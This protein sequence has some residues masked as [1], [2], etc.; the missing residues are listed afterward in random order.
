MSGRTPTTKEG[1]AGSLAYCL[2]STRR[3]RS[4]FRFAFRLLP[5][6]QRD[7]MHALYAFLRATDDLSDQPGD[8]TAKRTALH[9]WRTR[10]NAALR[11]VHSHRTHAALANTVTRFAIPPEYL[12]AV[13]DGCE[14]DLEPV[15]F[16]TFEPLRVYCYRVASAVGLACV[17]IWGLKAGEAF[18]AV[19]PFAEA[20]G[21]AFQLTNILRDVGEDLGR[22]RVYL[23]ADE[24]VRFDCPPESWH[25]KP[26]QFRELLRFQVDRAREFY[27][28]SE[29][30][31]G[32]L[33][34]EGRAVFTLMSDA[35]QKLLNR[36]ERAGCGVLTRR[37]RL[38]AWQKAG[39]LLRAWAG[40]A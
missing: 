36:V 10:L 22:G 31:V 38:S 34:P 18:A 29:P 24:L 13:I 14:T 33:T 16:A 11:G 19:E 25:T 30:L 8:P 37:V 17:R 27:R 1:F 9:H 23:P 21:Y 35:Y 32:V 20:A 26:E 7:A 2:R 15:R 4:S 6:P 40:R 28:Q 5:P 3:S 39:L 12:H